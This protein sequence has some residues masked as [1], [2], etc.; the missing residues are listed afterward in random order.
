MLGTGGYFPEACSWWLPTNGEVKHAWNY[1]SNTWYIFI[2][3]FLIIVLIRAKF[4]Q[5]SETVSILESSFFLQREKKRWLS[6]LKC[7]IEVHSLFRVREFLGQEAG[8]PKSLSWL[9]SV[10]PGNS[11]DILKYATV[12]STFLSIYLILLIDIY[13][14]RLEAQNSI[15]LLVLQRLNH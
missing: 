2:K 6:L 9:S 3:W 12:N 15:C 7:D 5:G 8:Y 10:P 1:T 13:N 4:T 14:Q 11:W